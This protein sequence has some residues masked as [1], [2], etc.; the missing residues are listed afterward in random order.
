MKMNEIVKII[1]VLLFT[2][3]SVVKEKITHYNNIRNEPKE[4]FDPGE[5]FA[6]Q[7]HRHDMFYKDNLD[8]LICRIWVSDSLMNEEG[9][10]FC[11]EPN[12]ICYVDLEGESIPV[13]PV[14]K[15]GIGFD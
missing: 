8:S 9:C 12:K 14:S 10:S 6:L 5:W 7:D 13:I 2:S 3:C 11:D 15:L 4:C 1:I